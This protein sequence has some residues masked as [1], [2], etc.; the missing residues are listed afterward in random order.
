MPPAEK[1]P[2]DTPPSG[3]PTETTLTEISDPRPLVP[4]SFSVPPPPPHPNFVFEVLGP[5]HNVAD[6]EAWSTSIEHI[7]ETPGFSAHGWPE[8]VYTL[9]ENLADL[10]EHRDHHQRRIDFAW[11]VLDPMTRE[12]VIGCVYLKPDPTGMA[13]A[14]ARSW[15]RASSADLDLLLRQHLQPWFESEWPLHVRYATA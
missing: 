4:R 11:T 6:L 8:R 1:T 14:E 3:S 12:R 13:E 2:S 15:V 5:E 9:K 7:H 10:R